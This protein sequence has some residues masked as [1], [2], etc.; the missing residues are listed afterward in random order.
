MYEKFMD[1]KAN[2]KKR[3]LTN[4]TIA[5]SEIRRE[6]NQN[7]GEFASTFPLYD[8]EG[9]EITDLKTKT[10]IL[11]QQASFVPATGQLKFGSDHAS[12][13][14]VM[15]PNSPGS[16]H[17]QQILTATSKMIDAALNPETF[18]ASTRDMFPEGIKV[19]YN[20][21][22]LPVTFRVMKTNVGKKVIG[23]N[24]RLVYPSNIQMV[25]GGPDGS[26][27]V[28][29]QFRVDDQPEGQQGMDE[30]INFMLNNAALKY[31]L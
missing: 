6:L 31:T 26:G 16:N 10:E 12:G 1:E 7:L 2:Y 14:G 13:M 24:Q 4:Y 11:K 23:D 27:K 9:N 28:V 30:F 17:T 15:N 20:G 25:I 21:Q 22:V 19:N 18:N 3:M 8:R 29:K 5:D